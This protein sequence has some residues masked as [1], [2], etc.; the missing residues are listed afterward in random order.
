MTNMTIAE[1]RKLTT[2][3]SESKRKVKNP[4]NDDN[5]VEHIE[6]IK[7]KNRLD[8]MVAE[9]KVIAYAHLVNELS[10][11][12]KAG[13][14]P[15]FAYLNKRKAEGWKPGVPDYLCVL[16]DKLVFIE[17][18]RCKGNSA[19]PEQK[20]WISA[21]NAAGGY[22]TVAKGSEAAIKYLEGLL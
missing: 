5:P 22:A 4:Y 3:S 18:K 2:N 1:Y 15:N 14:R 10:M 13:E 7:L 20:Q 12:R 8:E 6:A 16:P 17:L 21:I 19:T 9:G 11:N